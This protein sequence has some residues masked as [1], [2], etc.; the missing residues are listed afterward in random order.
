MC[1]SCFR[2]NNILSASYN[3][4]CIPIY[5]ASLLNI[6]TDL[7]LQNTTICNYSVE[8]EDLYIESYIPIMNDCNSLCKTTEYV[9][10][11]Q[12]TMPKSLPNNRLI[13]LFYWIGSDSVHISQEYLIYDIDGVVGST[14]GTLG[15]F[16]GFS[17]LNLFQSIFVKLK[18]HMVVH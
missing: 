16:L 8:I 11:L 17:F 13:E 6:S 12:T 5:Y 2:L 14:G 10:N 4:S 1:I 18:N 3:K 9:G 15:L 7:I